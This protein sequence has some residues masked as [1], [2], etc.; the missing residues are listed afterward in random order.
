MSLFFNEPYVGTIFWLTYRARAL[1]D[2]NALAF[3]CLYNAHAFCSVKSRA[4]VVKFKFFLPPNEKTEPPPMLS[5]NS[6]SYVSALYFA[7]D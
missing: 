3:L 1:Y 4:R 6:Y 7:S 5:W 2:Y